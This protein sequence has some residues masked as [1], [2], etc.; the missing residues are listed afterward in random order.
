V[1][2]PVLNELGEAGKMSGSCLDTGYELAPTTPDVALLQGALTMPAMPPMTFR[3]DFGVDF[4][5]VRRQAA[6]GSRTTCTGDS[7][8]S[9]E[10]TLFIIRCEPT[11]HDSLSQFLVH[12]RFAAREYLGG[13]Q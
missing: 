7:W 1:V 2:W 13:L 11:A 9:L 3:A 4:Q 12:S 5:Q 6:D 8:F 10:N